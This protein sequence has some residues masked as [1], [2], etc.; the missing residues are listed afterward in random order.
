MREINRMKAA[1][2]LERKEFERQ[3]YIF[4][5]SP[6]FFYRLSHGFRK[7][8]NTKIRYFKMHAESSVAMTI[9]TL[10]K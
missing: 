2:E 3:K 6:C 7:N 5:V 4:T 10:I 9:L 8:W 1:Q